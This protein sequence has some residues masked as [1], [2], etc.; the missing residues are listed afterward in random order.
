MHLNKYSAVEGLCLL[1][2]EQKE[3]PKMNP[4]SPKKSKKR[5]KSK[6]SQEKSTPLPNKKGPK[7]SAIKK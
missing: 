6:G 5:G 2:V 1:M 4:Q 3:D 7:A